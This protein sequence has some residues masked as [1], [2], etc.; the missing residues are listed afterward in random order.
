MRG[1]W[2]E[3]EVGNRVHLVVG[4]L[5]I[6]GARPTPR[7]AAVAARELFDGLPVVGDYPQARRLAAR[8]SVV[9]TAASY[10]RFCVPPEGWTCIGAEVQLERAVADIVWQ[11]DS[12]AV[13]VDELK[14]GPVGNNDCRHDQ[15]DRLVAGA[16][17]RWPTEFAGVRL[18]FTARPAASH[19]V[20]QRAGGF[21]E[22]VLGA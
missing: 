5:A 19:V 21:W 16:G 9:T 13:L 4:L 1:E 2:V 14:T 8:Q 3:R 6:G 12:G 15:I 20:A 7:E 18:V 17:N 11:H 22:G 10:F